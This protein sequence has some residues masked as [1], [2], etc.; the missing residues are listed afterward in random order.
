MV[1]YPDT[2]ISISRGPISLPKKRVDCRLFGHVKR[3][4]T[5]LRTL[6]FI[7]LLFIF[8]PCELG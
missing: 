6:E 5:A 3:I 4:V 7:P 8:A 2:C 1:S